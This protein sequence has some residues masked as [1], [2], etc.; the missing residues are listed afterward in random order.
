MYHSPVMGPFAFIDLETTGFDPNYD[1]IIEVAGVIW[2]DFEITARFESL[3]NPRAPVPHEITMLTG[4][5]NEMVKSAPLFSEVKKEIFEFIGDMPIV[6]HNIA[7]DAGFLRTHHA[8]FK[9]P[10]IDT[11]SLAR[12]FL[13]KEPSYSLE[14]L[15]KRHSLPLR[16]SHRAMA[17]VLTAVSFFE[18]MLK[19]IEALTKEQRSAAA[20]V[21]EKTDWYAAR[22]FPSI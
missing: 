7:F 18:F 17:D 15:M 13:R 8:Q 3:V 14:V 6:G 12:I 21:L 1:H 20:P 11:V 10:E 4:I 9:N 16:D 2:K 22:L 5:S 19:K